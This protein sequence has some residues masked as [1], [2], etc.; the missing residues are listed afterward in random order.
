MTRINIITGVVNNRPV[1]YD[2]TGLAKNKEIALWMFSKCGWASL[3]KDCDLA[4]H[5]ETIPWPE[6]S[7]YFPCD[8]TQLWVLGGCMHLN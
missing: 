5:V 2:Y 3:S 8:M 6:G 1:I 4:M 7:K